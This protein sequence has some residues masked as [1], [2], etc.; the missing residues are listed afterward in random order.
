VVL[1]L[2]ASIPNVIRAASRTTAIFRNQ[3]IGL[4]P[5]RERHR[6]S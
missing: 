6:E 3:F 5:P 1:V 4:S 2:P